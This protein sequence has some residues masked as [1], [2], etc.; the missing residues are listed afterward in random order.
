MGLSQ[1]YK[2]TAPIIFS[3]SDYPSYGQSGFA[4]K[5]TGE[6]TPPV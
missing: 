3:F 6:N 4:K 5:Q 2:A 1:V